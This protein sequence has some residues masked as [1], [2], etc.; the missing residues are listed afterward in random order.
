MI[1]WMNSSD[2]KCSKVAFDSDWFDSIEVKPSESAAKKRMEN[3][4]QLR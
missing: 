2:F 1:E 4:Q 3:N